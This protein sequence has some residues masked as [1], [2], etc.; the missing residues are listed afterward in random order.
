MVGGMRTS[1]VVRCQSLLGNSGDPP[2][3]VITFIVAGLSRFPP[4]RW[5]TRC[6][7]AIN[8]LVNKPHLRWWLARGRITY[9]ALYRKIQ[10][11]RPLLLFHY[12]VEPGAAFRSQTGNRCRCR[13][14]GV[15]LVN[16][17]VWVNGA[18]FA[19]GRMSAF[20]KAR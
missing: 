2:V 11:G 8:L 17:Q 9:H 19:G 6:S 10:S 7:P 16:K 14:T 5:K 20:T 1:W 15:H 18:A 3:F 13:G 4:S 12:P